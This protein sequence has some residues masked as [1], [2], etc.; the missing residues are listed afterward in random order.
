MTTPPF[1]SGSFGDELYASLEPILKDDSNNDWHAAVW[2]M[3][4]GLMFQDMHTYIRSRGISTYEVLLD[5]DNIPAANLPWLGQWVGV[6][7]NEVP[8]EPATADR[9]KV[10]S[11]AGFARGSVPAM[12][13][14]ISKTL[15]GTKHIF[16]RERWDGALDEPNAYH[17]TIDV[18][19]DEVPDP[20]A[21]LTAILKQKPAGIVLHFNTVDT[22]VWD[23]AVAT[24]DTASP[25]MTWDTATSGV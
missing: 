10:K 21:T 11:H 6:R 4:M 18:L 14:E 20:A 23:E 17:L 13:D 7:I 15:T 19:T 2:L 9:D 12:L 5:V 25:T 22:E 1:S 16:L 24:W 8:I 3:A